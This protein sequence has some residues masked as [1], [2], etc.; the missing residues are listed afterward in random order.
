MF[1]YLQIPSHGW[2]KTRSWTKT[3]DGQP[4]PEKLVPLE[5]Y[6]LRLIRHPGVVAFLDLLE[7]ETVF[8]LVMEHH[9]TP[10]YSSSN[11]SSPS[12]TTSAKV[13]SGS[14]KMS[15]ASQQH[16]PGITS[17]E[18]SISPSSTFSGSNSGKSNGDRDSSPPHRG[19]GSD[20]LPD[21]S[22]SSEFSTSPS[23][24]MGPPTPISGLPANLAAP[25][26]MLRRSSC[27]L[28]ECIEQH[29]RLPEEQ[30][31]LVFGQIVEVVFY[32]ACMGICHREPVYRPSL[33]MRC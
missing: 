6:V 12:A 24:S 2:V 19:S 20:Y 11:P 28:F 16:G 9:G 18:H 22:F 25:P 3:P 1:A 7:D 30:A 4:G 15:S 31:R 17:L 14:D 33:S 8:Y 32:L 21:I 5:A 29:S 26:P 10:W 13:L 23:S 27:D